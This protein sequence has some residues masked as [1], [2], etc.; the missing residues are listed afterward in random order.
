MKREDLKKLLGEN[1]T[2]EVLDTIMSM[3]GKDIETHKGK[4][5]TAE[6]SVKTLQT[7]LADAN[8]QIEDF[9]GLDIEGVKKAADEWKSKYEQA[10]QDHA[11]KLLGMEFDKDFDSALAGAKVK[12]P[13]EVKSKLNLEEL[14]D[15]S[16]K[17]IAERFT[18]QIGKIK[19]ESADLFVDSKEPPKI[20]KGANN[21]TVVTDAFEAAL[22]KGA[23]L[24]PPSESTT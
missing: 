13:N 4:L 18:E 16:G 19:T 3:N 1:V 21:Q 5:T 10:V 7:Q 17:F 12:Y 20:V 8:K 24:K 6:E 11:A 2:D 22:W 14:K 9:K 15:K 23:K